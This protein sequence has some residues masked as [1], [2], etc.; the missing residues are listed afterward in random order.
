MF[1]KILGSGSENI[2]FGSTTLLDI[3]EQLKTGRAQGNR[4]FLQ[5][6]ND[7]W[8]ALV[9]LNEARTATAS[10]TSGIQ[11]AKD[12]AMKSSRPGTP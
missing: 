8:S 12:T 3:V 1:N 11:G 4:K 6:V 7:K 2:K 5:G 9:Q 10:F